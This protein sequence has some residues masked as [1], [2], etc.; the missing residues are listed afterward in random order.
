MT[1]HLLFKQMAFYLCQESKKKILHLI[2]QE[3]TLWRKGERSRKLPLSGSLYQQQHALARHNPGDAPTEGI[4]TAPTPSLPPTPCI[5][6]DR[7]FPDEEAAAEDQGEKT[8]PEAEQAVKPVDNDENNPKET[9][10]SANDEGA[11]ELPPPSSKDASTPP[12]TATAAAGSG[13]PDIVSG[14]KDLSLKGGDEDKDSTKDLDVVS[15]GGAGAT[16]VSSSPEL[17]DSP[18]EMPSTPPDMVD[19]APSSPDIDLPDAPDSEPG[20]PKVQKLTDQTSITN[21]QYYQTE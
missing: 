14:T 10:A 4:R 6:A 5:D 7:P 12:P 16:T 2:I 20:S 11:T 21:C 8:R 3:I 15:G 17:V 19:D 13:P 18:P 9:E 1:V